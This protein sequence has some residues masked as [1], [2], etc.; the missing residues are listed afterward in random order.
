MVQVPLA[1][2]PRNDEGWTGLPFC[3][4]S[5]LIKRA[6]VVGTRREAARPK[7]QSSTI[8]LLKGKGPLVFPLS[9]PSVSSSPSTIRCHTKRDLYTCDGLIDIEAVNHQRGRFPCVTASAARVKRWTAT[10]AEK[11]RHASRQDI[12]LSCL[13]RFT[14]S[15]SYDKSFALD[16]INS[17]LSAIENFIT[18]YNKGADS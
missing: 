2:D 12:Q 6:I 5:D 16:T 18:I 7:K 1:K 3:S 10:F 9:C 17:M 13:D 8:P 14:T 11:L 4:F 15:N